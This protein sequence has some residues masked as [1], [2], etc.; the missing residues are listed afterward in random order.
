MSNPRVLAARAELSILT[1]TDSTW[2]SLEYFSYS[3]PM[4]VVVISLGLDVCSSVRVV[5]MRA[6]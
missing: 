4:V 3:S 5:K 2:K 6:A 1:G